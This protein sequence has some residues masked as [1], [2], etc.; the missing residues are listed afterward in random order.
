MTTQD[1]DT[2][3]AHVR[4]DSEGRAYTDCFYELDGH[5]AHSRLPGAYTDAGALR[6]IKIMREKDRNGPIGGAA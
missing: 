6:A 2:F 4:S 5:P 1:H 3:R